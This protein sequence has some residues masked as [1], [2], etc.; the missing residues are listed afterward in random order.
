MRLC[1]VRPTRSGRLLGTLVMVALI[2][3]GLSATSALAVRPL[4]IDV[5][6]W[7]GN[8]SQQNWND[9]HNLGGRDFVIVRAT[10]YHVPGVESDAH[11]SP[12]PYFVN[13][14]IRARN[15]GMLAGAYSFVRNTIRDPITEADFFLTYARPY[16]TS[17]YLRPVID[18]EDGTTAVGAANLSA[19]VNA[20]IDRVQQQTGV[21]AMIY[22]NSNYAKNYL[23]STVASRTLWLANWTY[24]SDPQTANPPP[25]AC[26][27]FG[28]WAF[29]QHS[30]Q[31]NGTD[32]AVPGIGGRVDLDVF[33]GTAA[34]L[35]NYVIGGG[36]Q[37]PTITQQPVEQM[38]C[39]GGMATFSVAAT[40]EGTLAYQWQKNGGNLG[41][42]GH[43]AG[44]TTTMLTVSSVDGSDS[45][46]YRCV[47]SNAGG[48][49]NSDPAALT[50]RTATSITQQPSAR[51]VCV[52][53]VTTFTVAATGDGPLMYQWQKGGANVS[54][55]GHY[56]GANAAVLTVSSADSG[57]VGDYRCVVS[58][59]CGNVASN[60]AAL[61]LRSATTITRQPTSQ[62][63]CAPAMAV[64]T[65][66][67]SGDGALQYQW[68]KGGTNLSDGG[69]YSG[70]TTPTL[71][72]SNVSRGDAS[73]YDCVVTGGCGAA[74]SDLATLAVGADAAADLD[75][76]CDVDLSDFSILQMCFSGP[77]RPL[78]YAE[79]GPADLDGDGD[80]DL[81]DFSM[82]QACFNGPNQPPACPPR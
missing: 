23:N 6:Y 48:S 61:T 1:A 16:V 50:V 29:W 33:N 79:C 47:V 70:T 71:T 63:L 11:G 27:V 10:H 76:D 43:Y 80:L 51:G 44:V 56:A 36:T 35:Q 25:G 75:A 12:D 15:A 73:G 57:D 30:N 58:G 81:G 65:V 22:C 59:G 32:V 28:T 17:G 13:N 3:A 49:T 67:A 18:L 7:Q 14:M 31:G 78:P 82:F 19:W 46:N 20:W 42:G 68:R 40:G 21:E 5:S 53:G 54:D 74:V 66:V 37:P 38:I 69:R 77:N 9:V 4:G 52:G 39:P 62:H 55:G 60:A 8:L 34:Q 2:V 45:A 72:I 41:N 26:G 24:P 64:F